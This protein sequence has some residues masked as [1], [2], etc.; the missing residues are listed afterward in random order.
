VEDLLSNFL[1]KSP[2]SLLRRIDPDDHYP[3]FGD[4]ATVE[5]TAP[6]LGRFFLKLDQGENHALW[7]N[8]KVGYLGNELAQVER[9]LYGANL[10]YQSRGITSSGEQRV[11]IDGFAAE[12]GTVA[13]REE[14]RGTGGSLYFLGQQDLLTGPGHGRLA[15]LP[16]PAGPAD[17]LGAG[18][19]RG[20]GQGLGPRVE[21]R[22]A[23][24]GARL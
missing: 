16:G 3:T 14:F 10:H 20:A 8:F 22:T 7:G 9:G 18:P 12:P 5:E 15:L 1:D 19:D 4:D 11:V 21:R 2:E 17:G 6:T 24:A 23:H 13:R